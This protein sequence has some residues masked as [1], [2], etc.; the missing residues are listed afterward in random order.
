MENETK[1]SQ[2]TALIDSE[3]ES[4][5]DTSTESSLNMTTGSS[6]ETG[7]EMSLDTSTESSLSMI[8]ESSLDI[9]TDLSLETSILSSF[10]DSLYELNENI[11]P[12][13]EMTPPPSPQ[14][15]EPSFHISPLLNSPIIAR[16]TR[17]KAVSNKD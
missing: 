17:S 8:N 11:L 14:P 6:L 10:S 4:S 2:E 9:S 7:T 13:Y 5:L 1:S 16:L 3:M 12:L 15:K